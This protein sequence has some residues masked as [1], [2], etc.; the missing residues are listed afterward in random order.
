M[1]EESMFGVGAVMVELKFA[2]AR[3]NGG[4]SL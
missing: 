4:L 2:T 3:K 1:D